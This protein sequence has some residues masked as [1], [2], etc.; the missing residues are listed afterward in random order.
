MRPRRVRASA[1]S[2]GRAGAG[3]CASARSEIW[4]KRSSAG[5]QKPAGENAH[6]ERTARPRASSSAIAPPIELPATCGRS[7]P[8]SAKNHSNASAYA[9]IV[10]SMPLDSGA[11]RPKPGESQAITSNSPTSRSIT[12]SHACQW[13]PMPCRSTSGGPSPSR[14]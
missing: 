3:V 6:T 1:S 10:G 2:A 9:G 14:W 8:S 12:G 7:R 13:C 11:E 4:Q 5:V